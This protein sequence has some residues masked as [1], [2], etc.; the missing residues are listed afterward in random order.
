MRVSD[1]RKLNRVGRISWWIA[2]AIALC[3]VSM[4]SIAVDLGRTLPNL[5]ICA[6]AL[7]MTL[8]AAAKKD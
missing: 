6:A 2:A 4:P 5:G 7:S 8:V 3:G 1:L